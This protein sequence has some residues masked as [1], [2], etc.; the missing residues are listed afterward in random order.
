MNIR[1]YKE[2]DAMELANL[3]HDSVHAI[4]TKVYSEE[5]KEAWAPT[6]SDYSAWKSRLVKKQP[7]VAC[8]K[9]VIVGFIELEED[10]HI[11]C[12]YVHK[13]YQGL[14][15]GSRLLEHLV[16]KA[17]DSGIASLYVEASK[18][19]VPLFEK[20]DFR[21][22]STNKKSLRGQILINYHMTLQR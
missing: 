16:Q 17:H 8:K 11:D 21:Y 13:D 15:I 5:E 7:F 1:S 22:K 14:G 2:S 12:L 18:V 4:S 3:F 10:G 9:N 20:F 6:P 19:A